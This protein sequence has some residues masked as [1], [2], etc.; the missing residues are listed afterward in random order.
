ME[1]TSTVDIKKKKTFTPSM[2]FL[3]LVPFVLQTYCTVY[4][5]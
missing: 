2:V 4:V 5:L 1:N 3:G